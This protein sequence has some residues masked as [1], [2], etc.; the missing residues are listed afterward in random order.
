[1]LLS[2]ISA[3]ANTSMGNGKIISH[4]DLMC[5]GL[6]IRLCLGSSIMAT[7]SRKLLLFFRNLTLLPFYKKIRVD[8]RCASEESLKVIANS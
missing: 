6:V 4:M 3:M 5:S 8:G 7:W 2:F 1:M